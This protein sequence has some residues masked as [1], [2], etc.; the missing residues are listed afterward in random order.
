LECYPEHT[1][2]SKADAVGSKQLME[3]TKK[4]T[5]GHIFAFLLY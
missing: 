3:K 5:D 1:A 2:G 4:E